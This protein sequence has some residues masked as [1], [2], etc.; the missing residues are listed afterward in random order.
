MRLQ[1]VILTRARF[2]PPRRACVSALRVSVTLS[3]KRE[4]ITGPRR[5]W[6]VV[7]GE[8]KDGKRRK[9]M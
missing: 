9:E 5:W 1:A 6:M 4:S 2:S 7:D 3:R 8:G